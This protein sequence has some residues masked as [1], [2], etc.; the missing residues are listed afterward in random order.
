MVPKRIIDLIMGLLAIQSPLWLF[1]SSFGFGKNK[2]KCVLSK[3]WT[4][5]HPI[6][7]L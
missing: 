6:T 4:Y 1:Y 2:V 3:V 5:N 7:K